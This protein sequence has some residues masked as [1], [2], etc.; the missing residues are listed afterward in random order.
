MRQQILD[1]IKSLSQEIEDLSIEKQSLS[2]RLD[3]IDV[4]MHQ[5]VGALYT[6]QQLIN[7]ENQLSEQ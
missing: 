7:Q 4:R 5:L 3:D 2:D 1:K 6:L